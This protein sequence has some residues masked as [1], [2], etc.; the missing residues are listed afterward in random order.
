MGGSAPF[1]GL[2]GKGVP[3]IPGQDGGGYPIPGLDGE[4]VLHPRS[5]WGGG[6]PGQD[7]GGWG[8]WTGGYPHVKVRTGWGTPPSGLD[9]VT[10]PSRTRWGTP[11][12]VERQSSIASTCYAAGSMPLALTQDFLVWVQVCSGRSTGGGPQGMNPRL[13]FLNFYAVLGKNWSNCKLAP[14]GNSGSATCLVL[15]LHTINYPNNLF[16]NL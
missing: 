9:G 7:R 2:D 14:P 1:L 5:G 11:P 16:C 8:V 15:T 12:L 10:P 6:T 3:P 4:E 13:K